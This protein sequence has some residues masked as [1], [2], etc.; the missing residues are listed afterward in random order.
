MSRRSRATRT[1]AAMTNTTW[2]MRIQAAMR[3]L[4]LE[5]DEVSFKEK[6]TGIGGV[7]SIVLLIEITTHFGGGRPRS[8]MRRVDGSQRRVAVRCAPRPTLPTLARRRRARHLRSDRSRRRHRS[9]RHP[10]RRRGVCRRHLDPR[11]A[12]FNSST[13]R[14]APPRS[15]PSSAARLSHPWA[16]T[17]SGDRS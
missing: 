1:V 15:R 3:R 16:T 12:R 9:W 4:G 11:N 2:P 17:S 7:V 5:L 8:L 6:A 13:H 14:R 10:G